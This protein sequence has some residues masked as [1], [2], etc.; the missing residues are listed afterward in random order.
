MNVGGHR[1]TQYVY[2]P[3]PEPRLP[4]CGFLPPDPPTPPRVLP[5]LCPAPAL[6]SVPCPSRA[7]VFPMPSSA[8]Q[9]TPACLCRRCLSGRGSVL[10]PRV[11]SL[12]CSSHLLDAELPRRHSRTQP[13]SRQLPAALMC[14]T[15]NPFTSLWEISFEWPLKTISL[16][17][18]NCN[19]L[20]QD[21]GSGRACA[22]CCE[23]CRTGFVTGCF[24]H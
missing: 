10:P 1:S 9:G 7:P 23:N 6:V 20:A 22:W 13:Q 11:W 14:N 18:K 16:H 24:G 12:S 21:G 4:S 15:I 8:L 3:S 2:L 19:Y 17:K 5:C